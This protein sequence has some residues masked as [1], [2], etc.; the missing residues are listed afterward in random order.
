[1]QK[2][3]IKLQGDKYIISTT[4]KGEK[5][6]LR[7]D[8]NLKKDIKIIFSSESFDNVS[9]MVMQTLVDQYINRILNSLK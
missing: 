8:N 7:F 4:E 5:Y 1:M 6:I 3:K 2:N 9:L